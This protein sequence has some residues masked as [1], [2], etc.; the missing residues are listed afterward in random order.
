MNGVDILFILL[1]LGS[2]ALGFFQGTIKLVVAIIAFYV[3]I[4][5]A[6]L[7]FPIVGNFFRQR[8]RSTLEVGQITAF[9]VI[10]LFSFLLLTVAGLY[11]FRYAKMPASLDFV[12]RIVG[13]MLGLLLGALFLGMLSILLQGLFIDRDV[14]GSVTFPIIGALQRN[15]R[16]SFLV[17]F[18]GNQILPL[19][20]ASV[21]PALPRESQ[22]IFRVRR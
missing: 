15:V 13:T 19:I 8:F 21:Q 10:L 5:L 16:S 7:Y 4:I 11:T 20:Y 12:D 6:S 18:F 2:L 3:S 17:A 1:L 9:A 22:F 14:A